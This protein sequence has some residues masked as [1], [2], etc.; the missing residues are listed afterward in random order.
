MI[1]TVLYG[2]LRFAK[3]PDDRQVNFSFTKKIYATLLLLLAEL[4]ITFIIIVPVLTEIDELIHLKVSDYTYISFLETIF[5]LVIGVPFIEEMVFRYFLRYGGLRAKIFSEV[6]WKRIFPFLVYSSVI[7]FGLMHLT[8]YANYTGLFFL[9]A[10]VIVLTQLTGGLIITF[11][12]V[13][14]GFFWGF[15]YHCLWN[16]L[17]FVAIPLADAQFVEPY[18]E[19]TPDYSVTIEEQLFFNKQKQF[20]K[21]DSTG[22]RI[23]KLEVEHFAMQHLID[24][25]YKKSGYI[26]DDV[27]VNLHLESKKGI[28]KQQFLNILKK[29]YEIEK[30]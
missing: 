29:E 23:Y 21:I 18:A 24:T 30:E 22:G 27:L 3:K 16:F 25:I 9:L 1:G 4:T 5:L 20:I 17:V 11:L 26:T 2:L 15:L 13:R 6:R 8:N 14:F 7:S 19:K 28:T 10:P 12:R